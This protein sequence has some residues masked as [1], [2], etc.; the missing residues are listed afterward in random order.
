[1]RTL[2]LAYKKIDESEFTAWN[3]EFQKAKTSLGGDRE[4]MLERVSDM[5]E[6]ELVLV[7][8]TAVEDKLQKG[9]IKSLVS[10]VK[11]QYA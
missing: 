6:R 1:M 10:Y 11:C 9:V 8:C 3:T 7:G 2:A 5:I 4:T